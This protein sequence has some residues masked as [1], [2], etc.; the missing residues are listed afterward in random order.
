MADP[1]QASRMNGAGRL[2]R[3]LPLLA[4]LLAVAAVALLAAG[5]LGWRAGWWHFR[6]AFRALMPGAFDCAI[7]AM[8]VAVVALLFARRV[9]SQR[10]V[11]I[12][13]LAF[14]LGVAIAYVPWHYNGM[15]GM[16]PNDITTDLD[17]PP[18]YVAVLALRKADHSQNAGDYKTAKAEQQRRNY[19]DIAPVTLARPPAEA[20]ARALKMAQDL[21]WTIVAADAEAGRI[22]ASQ[23]SRWF[24][25]TDDVVIRITPAGAASRIDIRSSSRLGT[26]DFGVNARRVRAFVA[27]LRGN[28]GG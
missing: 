1:S 22:E 12:G 20:F 21:G 19:P 15:R 13:A 11:A 27:A 16:V 25:F 6:V 5:P 8:A 9:M 7:A 4:L 23:R 28:S 18:A 3:R 17:N 14:I 26:G 24:G 10:Q 2:L